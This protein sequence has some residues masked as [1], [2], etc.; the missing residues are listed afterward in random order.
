MDAAATRA[1]VSRGRTA[2]VR[3]QNRVVLA[4]RRWRQARNVTN[5]ASD[6]SKTARF[7]RARYKR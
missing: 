1:I 2:L 6:G 3:T 4:P 5:D 7:P